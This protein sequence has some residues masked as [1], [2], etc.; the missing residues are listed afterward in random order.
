MELLWQCAGTDRPSVYDIKI[1][2]GS[3]IFESLNLLYV[4]RYENILYPNHTP[5][6]YIK[7]LSETVTSLEK[8]VDV[9]PHPITVYRHLANDES[10]EMLEKYAGHFR[11]AYNLHTFFKRLAT[12]LPM[13]NVLIETAVRM[14]NASPNVDLMPFCKM[15]IAIQDMCPWIYFDED[16]VVYDGYVFHYGDGKVTMTFKDDFPLYQG[17]VFMQQLCG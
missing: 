13:Y 11:F 8:I 2:F 4:L 10:S 9:V 6:K 17:S 14:A 12:N 7:I 16:G 5:N 3:T 15:S 1:A